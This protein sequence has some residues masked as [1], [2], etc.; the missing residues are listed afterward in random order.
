M[1][2][3]VPLGTGDI[4]VLSPPGAR[5]LD[6]SQGHTLLSG[7]CEPLAWHDFVS[8]VFRGLNI[9]LQ[10]PRSA[11][12]TWCYPKGH[13]SQEREWSFYDGAAPHYGQNK[14]QT[15]LSSDKSS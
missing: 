3:G 14:T 12:V 9:L 2:Q 6:P 4:T 15:R 5:R 1:P 11:H 8:K 10:P 13:S 7:S